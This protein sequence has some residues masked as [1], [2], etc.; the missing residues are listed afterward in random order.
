VVVVRDMEDAR[1]LSE[2]ILRKR[3]QKDFEEQFKDKFT[4]GLKIDQN[5]EKLGVINQTT[6]LATETQEIA[7]FFKSV[8][9]EKYGVENI[10]K[11]YADT[12]DTLCYATNENQDAA[13]GLLETNADLAIVVGG[14]NSSN[15]S[16]LVELCERKFPTYFISSADEIKNRN[17][18]HHYNYLQKKNLVTNNFLP[19]KNPLKIIITSG[20][21]CPDSLLEDIIHKINSYFTGVQLPEE[22]LKHLQPFS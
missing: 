19:A 16:H 2:F 1:K 17:V 18:I 20:A 10:S 3:S 13:Q 22:V 12:R 4:P 11:H 9:I 14:Y 8:M 15:T 7:D 21:S 6:M 5:F